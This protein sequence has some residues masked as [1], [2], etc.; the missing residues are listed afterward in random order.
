MTDVDAFDG[1]RPMPVRARKG[2][3]TGRFHARTMLRAKGFG[4][5]NGGRVCSPR[6]ATTFAEADFAVLQAIAAERGAPISSIVRDA[7]RTW[8]RDSGHADE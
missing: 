5:K 2:Q 6:I 1:R 8:L 4:R 7:V 3:N